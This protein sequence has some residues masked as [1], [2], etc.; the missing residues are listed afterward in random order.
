M[1]N[2]LPLIVP[3]QPID[4]RRL[5]VRLTDETVLKGTHPAAV[6]RARRAVAGDVGYGA[7]GCE[8][9]MQA[10]CNPT[11]LRTRMSNAV[12]RRSRQRVNCASLKD[13]SAGSSLSNA[14]ASSSKC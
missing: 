11:S 3:E 2:D 14:E 7:K 12:V 4:T 10:H 5:L 9:W 8:R 6:C 1:F 13:F